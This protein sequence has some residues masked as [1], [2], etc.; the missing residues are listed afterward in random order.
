VSTIDG[1]DGHLPLDGAAIQAQLDSLLELHPTALVA[2]IGAD[3]IF[4]RTRVAP[5][6]GRSCSGMAS[7]ARGYGP[8]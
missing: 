5:I 8:D 1:V 7:V 4:G 2:A 3:G 6:A